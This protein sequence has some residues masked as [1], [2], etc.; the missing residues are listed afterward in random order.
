[1]TTLA[2]ADRSSSNW[3]AYRSD[4]RD[5][6]VWCANAGVPSLPATPETAGAYLAY[7]ATASLN[8]STIRR[9]AAAIGF[10][11]TKGGHAAPT[12]SPHVNRVLSGVCRKLGTAS[13]Q[14]GP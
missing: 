11:H 6:E 14:K 10:M 3:R 1:V 5:F 12:A 7:L 13:A 9:R 8:A 4:F 2:G